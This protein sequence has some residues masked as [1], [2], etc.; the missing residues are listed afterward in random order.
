MVNIN[1]MRA[2]VKHN[3]FKQLKQLSK[4]DQTKINDFIHSLSLNELKKKGLSSEIIYKYKHATS[5]RGPRK[6]LSGGMKRGR[7]DDDEPN[8]RP[9]L[10]RI[11]DMAKGKPFNERENAIQE[12]EEQLKQILE[13]ELKAKTQ[14]DRA[15]LRT[16]EA[17]EEEE[18]SLTK[19]Q[20]I[21]KQ[22]KFLQSKTKSTFGPIHDLSSIKEKYLALLESLK[23]I[24]TDIRRE[25]RPWH[26]RRDSRLHEMSVYDLL[27]SEMT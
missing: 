25:G 6:N 17:Q 27:Y 10:K 23:V 2:I 1:A 8:K 22:R 9:F 12:H 20:L 16:K 3:V 24:E 5:K 19:L 21:E 7:D 15:Q 18:I 13:D 4:S 11:L 14:Y 26:N